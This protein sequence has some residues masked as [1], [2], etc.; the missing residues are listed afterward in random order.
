MERRGWKHI[1][2]RLDKWVDHARE[3]RHRLIKRIYEYDAIP[4][5]ASDTYKVKFAPSEIFA[6]IRDLAAETIDI[7][8][9]GIKTLFDSETFGKP[10]MTL[11]KNLACNQKMLLHCEQV[12]GQ[13]ESL[14]GD[15]E[16][17]SEQM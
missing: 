1:E 14:G 9:S 2:K 15:S 17:L 13:I 8:T 3:R 7:Y 4:D 6:D 12:L 10:L 11:K 16:Y 5:P